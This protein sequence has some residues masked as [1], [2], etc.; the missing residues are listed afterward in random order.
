MYSF[1]FPLSDRDS[2]TY[3]K[4][5][6]C[7][8]SFFP[9]PVS[10]PKEKSSGNKVDSSLDKTLGTVTFKKSQHY[11]QLR[12]IWRNGRH[13]T[14]GVCFR[15]M[16][17]LQ[18]VDCIHTFLPVVKIII[19]WDDVGFQLILSGIFIFIPRVGFS[20]VR[21]KSWLSHLAE[22]EKLNTKKTYTR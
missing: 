20:L 5:Q 15:K 1:A 14:V 12:K 13:Q 2:Q 8:Q 6:P 19:M 11:R 22:I 17:I 9:F 10:F 16:S 4:F 21:I 18:R 7:F 3:K